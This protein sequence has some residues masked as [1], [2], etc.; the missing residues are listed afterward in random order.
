MITRLMAQNPALLTRGTT[1]SGTIARVLSVL[2]YS[3]LLIIDV[4][5]WVTCLRRAL[6]PPGPEHFQF[7]TLELKALRRSVAKEF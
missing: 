2:W 6:F 1:Q 3:N 4:G 7:Q 5:V